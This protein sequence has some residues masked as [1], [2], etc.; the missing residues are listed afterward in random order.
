M[1]ILTKSAENSEIKTAFAEI[2]LNAPPMRGAEYLSIAVLAESES[3]F[4]ARC[5]WKIATFLHEKRR[6]AGWSN[7]SASC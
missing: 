7:N 6:V 2:I 1:K 4:F 3:A 5:R